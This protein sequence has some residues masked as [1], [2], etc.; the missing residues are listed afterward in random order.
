MEIQNNLKNKT[1]FE[2]TS[3]NENL[4]PQPK[5]KYISI[6]I[7]NTNKTKSKFVLFGFNRFYNSKNFGSDKGVIVK[8]TNSEVEYSEILADSAFNPF[9]CKKTKIFSENQNNINKTLCFNVKKNNESILFPIKMQEYMDVYNQLRENS[10]QID[11]LHCIN[12]RTFFE[13]E[14]EGNS[15]IIIVFYLQQSIAD[16]KLSELNNINKE[17]DIN[18]S[19]K[20]EK[21]K[22]KFDKILSLYEKIRIYF[23]YKSILKYANKRHKETSKT[24]K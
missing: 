17:E 20:I 14:I 1:M 11:C 16:L 3:V 8:S 7:K 22:T 6:V 18:S 23:K 4:K 5:S 13:G 21:P 15:E 9:Y 19:D 12:S 10:V 24:K 2:T